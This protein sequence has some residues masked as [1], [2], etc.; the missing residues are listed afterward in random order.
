MGEGATATFTVPYTP[1]SRLAKQI[2]E[3]LATREQDEQYSPQH[4]TIDRQSISAA[5]RRHRQTA[6]LRIKGFRHKH[7]EL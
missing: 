5:T 4:K 7:M 2:R 6:R 3:I 1:G